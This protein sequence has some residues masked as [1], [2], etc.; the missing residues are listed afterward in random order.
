MVTEYII[1]YIVMVYMIWYGIYS[2]VY[3][4]CPLCFILKVVIVSGFHLYPFRTEKLSPSAPMV[5]HRNAGE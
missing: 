5:L 2:I 1:W 4:K 3:I